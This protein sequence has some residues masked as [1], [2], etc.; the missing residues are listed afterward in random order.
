[1]CF[2]C[3]IS[4]SLN[5]NFFSL[6]YII[7]GLIY[8]ILIGKLSNSAKKIKYLSE[9]FTLGYAGYQLL[10]KII[11]IILISQGTDSEKEKQITA[12]QGTLHLPPGIKGA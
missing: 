6:Y 3:L 8:L 2:L 4:S 11:S 12:A 1:M 10:F 9:I 5:F 7:I